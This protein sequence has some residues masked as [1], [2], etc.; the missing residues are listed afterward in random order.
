MYK[1]L[2]TQLRKKYDKAPMVMMAA[3][4]G[5]KTGLLPI[6]CHYPCRRKIDY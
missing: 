1:E 5:R 3:C 6:G 4:I 2:V